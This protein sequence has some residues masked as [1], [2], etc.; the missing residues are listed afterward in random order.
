MSTAGSFVT[1]VRVVLGGE[2]SHR[3]AG[4]DPRG[5]FPPGLALPLQGYPRVPFVPGLSIAVV[6]LVCVFVFAVL[7]HL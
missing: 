1:L 6:S 2:Q 4:S 3:K 7:G 5:T